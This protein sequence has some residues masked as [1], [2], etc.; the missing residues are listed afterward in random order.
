MS[1]IVMYL[2]KQLINSSRILYYV[3][4]YIYIGIFQKLRSTPDYM[5]KIVQNIII[6]NIF[7]NH[8]NWRRSIFFGTFILTIVIYSR[9]LFLILIV[10]MCL[11][12]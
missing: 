11:N 2:Y 4:I 5:H 9:Y 8:R 6:Y 12:N 7:K 3:Y 1:P 10:I